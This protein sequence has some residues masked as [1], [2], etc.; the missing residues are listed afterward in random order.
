MKKWC[1]FLAALMVPVI[2]FSSATATQTITIA[3]APVTRFALIGNDPVFHMT[4]TAIT[5]GSLSVTTVHTN[6]SYSFICTKG[7]E[8]KI[9]AQLDMEM[10]QGVQLR[11]YL[12][13]PSGA[14]STGFQILGVTEA[15]LVTNISSTANSGNADIIYELTVDFAKA[16]NDTISRDII[17]TFMDD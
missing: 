1:F 17:Y 6:I 2:A 13:A 16:S 10:P 3:I 12:A 5:N 7:C 8:K 11:V 15:D 9:I 14:T 4:P